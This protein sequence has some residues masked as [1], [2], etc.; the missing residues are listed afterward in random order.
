MNFHAFHTELLEFIQHEH[1][2]GFLDLDEIERIHT[3]LEISHN[4]RVFR[5]M[6]EEVSVDFNQAQE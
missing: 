5:L 2:T 6:I 1:I 3:N 4:E